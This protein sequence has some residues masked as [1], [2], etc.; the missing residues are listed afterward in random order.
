MLFCT[1]T[2]DIHI[3]YPPTFRQ[4]DHNDSMG[5]GTGTPP[6]VFEVTA[7]KRYR[8]RVISGANSMCP[9]HVSVE[10]HSMLMIASDGAPFEPREVKS[11]IMHSAER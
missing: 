11:F 6:A 8:F 3:G 4:H 1:V 7:G 10:G 5:N 2:P 9:V